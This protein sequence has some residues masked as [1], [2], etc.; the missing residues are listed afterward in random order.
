MFNR[1][2]VFSGGMCNYVGAEG[3]LARNPR[4]DELNNQLRAKGHEVF[5][6]QIDESTHGRPYNYD[7][8]GPA[9]QN[10]RAKAHVL[11]YQVGSETM[12]G[13]T[14]LEVEN[15]VKSGRKVILWLSG[16]IDSKGRPLFKPLGLN[17]ESITDSATKAHVLQMLKQ[18]NS[19]RANLLDFTKE[20]TNLRVVATE[21]GVIGAL[22][23]F[24]I[25]I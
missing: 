22:K 18:G 13:V 19:M 15:D 7:I 12:A 21:G 14:L 2:I 1:K 8:D 9:E 16:E 6:P 23:E 4:R 11:I 3:S 20:A 10:A 25:R 24:G 17:P 5:D